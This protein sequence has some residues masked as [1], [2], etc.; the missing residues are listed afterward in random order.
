MK[1]I[2][3]AAMAVVLA[4]SVSVGAFAASSKSSVSE[5]ASAKAADGTVLQN[6]QLVRSDSTGPEITAAQA[7]TAISG[8]SAT[9]TV[10]VLDQFD[11]TEKDVA[12]SKFPLTVTFN[13]AG[14]TKD[15]DVKILHFENNAWK[16]VTVSVN[17]G[18]VT[19]TFA[20]LSPI[21]IVKLAPAA[22]APSGGT[23]G[24]SPKTGEAGHTA[25]AV[26]ALLVASVGMVFL[27][28]RKSI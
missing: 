10:S 22:S 21:A 27:T 2:V 26:G 25:L 12:Q 18:T 16:D 6:S 3:S 17:D 15:M 24:T 23:P 20:S 8:S 11:L 7:K 4:L 13:V 14:V 19:G 1:K 5:I 28:K 9:D